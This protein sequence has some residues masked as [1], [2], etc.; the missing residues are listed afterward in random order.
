MAQDLRKLLLRYYNYQTDLQ[1]HNLELEELQNNP[2]TYTNQTDIGTLQKVLSY[3][4]EIENRYYTLKEVSNQ[5]VAFNHELVGLFTKIGVPP[6]T[7]IQ[8]TDSRSTVY[9]WH[10]EDGYVEWEVR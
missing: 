7:K 4:T 6:N 8:V 1:K 9:F 2:V 10:D 3:Q 5:L